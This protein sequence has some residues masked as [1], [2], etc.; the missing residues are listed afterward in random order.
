MLVNQ[1]RRIK[2]SLEERF[3]S[4]S[5]HITDADERSPLTL[6]E[7][8]GW[9]CVAVENGSDV[10]QVNSNPSSMNGKQAIV[11]LFNYAI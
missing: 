3:S 6:A 1:V 8:F 4:S 7:V 9:E 11:V 10:L 5:Y 2:V